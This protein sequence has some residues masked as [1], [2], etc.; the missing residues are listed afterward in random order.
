MFIAELAFS[1]SAPSPSSFSSTSSN[2]SAA[3]TA[4][5][6][7][8]FLGVDEI[9]RSG[10]ENDL[11]DLIGGM[12]DSP[13]R[14]P[15]GLRVAV[16]PIVTSLSQ[17]RMTKQATLSTRPLSLISMP[18]F[19]PGAEKMFLRKLD[20]GPEFLPIIR[21]FCRSLGN[22]G[23]LLEVLYDQLMILSPGFRQAL[24]SPAGSKLVNA[25]LQDVI[26]EVRGKCFF[27]FFSNKPKSLAFPVCH[28]LLGHEIARGDLLA[29]CDMDP[30][31]LQ[32]RG[33]F[34]GDASVKDGRIIPIMSALQVVTWA[35]FIE[36]DASCRELHPLAATLIKVLSIKPPFSG[37][38]FEVFHAGMC[39]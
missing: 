3:S 12:S 2:S 33:I 18:V 24:L 38:T 32:Q 8:I 13:L 29:G 5:T 6:A 27:H 15:N 37:S 9:S 25:I 35:E 4:P 20:L 1:A 17:S 7:L 22:P 30:D 14:L 11:I 26:R 21:Y 19:L 10:C 31:E 34:I 28:A 39:A 23:R 36:K 16:L